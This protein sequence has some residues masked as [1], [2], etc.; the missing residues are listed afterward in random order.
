MTWG[1]MRRKISSP[2]SIPDTRYCILLSMSRRLDL[3]FSALV[4]PIDFLAL[5]GAALT[6]YALRFSEAFIEYRPVLQQLRLIDYLDTITLSIV[7]WMLLFAVAGLYAIRPRRLW[8][9]IG[10]VVLASTAGIMLVI[11]GVFFRREVTT[12]RFLVLAIW[13]L[14]IIYV[15]LARYILRLLRRALLK[16]GIGHQRLVIIGQG[17]PAKDLLQIYADTPVLG[18]TVVKQC[19]TWNADVQTQLE[20]LT[21]RH[22]LDAV[23]IADT[24]L[25]KAQARAVITFCADQHVTFRYLADLFAAN[26]AQVE[27]STAE[28][29]PIIEPKRTPLDGWGRITKRAFDMTCASVVLLITS[30]VLLM[31]VLGRFFEDGTPVIFENTRVGERGR[32]FRLY[33]IRSMWRKYCLGPQFKVRERENRQLLAQIMR[34]H[35]VGQG[36][37]KRLRDSDPRITPL[38]HFIRRW[39]IDELPQ[40]WNVIKGEMSIVGPRPHEPEEVA[41]YSSEQRRVFAIKPGITGMAQISGRRDLSFDD[42]VR[43]DTWY[44]EHWSLA[45]DLYIVLKTPWVVM[46]KKGVY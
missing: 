24:D 5:L 9:E 44:I 2:L 32:V 34:E 21:A 7:V 19:R 15:C 13:G 23:L 35:G 42:E 30:P 36:P 46:K 11:T 39:S 14:A 41:Q 37:V 16:R 6:A 31:S 3:T 17:K 10:R 22:E 12:S 40:M 20:R 26:F 8:S 18:Y 43:L 29:I 45:L 27:I 38:G 4:L 33:K 25:S 28:G 1:W